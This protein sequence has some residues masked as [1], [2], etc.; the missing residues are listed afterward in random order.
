VNFCTLWTKACAPVCVLPWSTTYHY[1][2][3]AYAILYY[4]IYTVY[5]VYYIF[6]YL[7]SVL[8][9]V[10]VNSWYSEEC[11][12]SPGICHNG[13]LL[14]IC[15]MQ[16]CTDMLLFS[17]PHIHPSQMLV[18]PQHDTARTLVDLGI[19]YGWGPYQHQYPWHSC[20]HSMHVYVRMYIIITIATQM[21]SNYV[22][23]VIMM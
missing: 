20:M 18:C 19:E 1:V 22:A 2:F 3:E 5:T 9:L 8:H 23:M 11:A 4:Y 16:E 7:P 14:F 17:S 10:M 13:I 21:L 15:I 12:V 6:Y